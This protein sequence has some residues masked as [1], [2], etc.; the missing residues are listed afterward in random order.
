MLIS[1]FPQRSSA[2]VRGIGDDALLRIHPGR[3]ESVHE[4]RGTC[5]LAGK[6]LA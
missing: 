4:K 1:F 2:G 5:K 6:K 3:V